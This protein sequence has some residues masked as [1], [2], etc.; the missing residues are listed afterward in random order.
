[1]GEVSEAIAEYFTRGSLRFLLKVL[2]AIVLTLV[3]VVLFLPNYTG[4]AVVFLF[5]VVPAFLITYSDSWDH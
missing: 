5:I 3:F 2:S 1:M 4:Y